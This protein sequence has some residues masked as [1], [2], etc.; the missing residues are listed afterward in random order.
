VVGHIGAV[1]VLFPAVTPI[2]R[3]RCGR[4]GPRLMLDCQG[5]RRRVGCGPWRM[6]A[7]LAKI[8][9]AG[10]SG[11]PNRLWLSS[12]PE[13]LQGCHRDDHGPDGCLAAGVAGAGAG[14]AGGVAPGAGRAGTR[15]GAG[16]GPRGGSLDPHAG[17]RGGTSTAACIPRRYR[18]RNASITSLARSAGE[19]RVIPPTDAPPVPDQSRPSRPPPPPSAKSIGWGGHD[20]WQAWVHRARRVAVA[21]GKA[22]QG[23]GTRVL[24]WDPG[25]ECLG[26]IHSAIT[27]GW[28]SGLIADAES[29]LANQPG[30]HCG[31][32]SGPS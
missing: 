15:L 21:I 11:A 5:W 10:N 30:G 25:Q 20:A 2:E 3:V 32:V 22:K 16:L 17:G 28:S 13:H 18:P 23:V 12:F 7:E 8:R 29:E 9:G 6:A 1:A 31:A 27:Q 14:V 4:N 19:L 24:A 26:L